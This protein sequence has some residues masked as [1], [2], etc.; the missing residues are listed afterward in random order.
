MNLSQET[1]KPWEVHA[2]ADIAARKA[3]QLVWT[4]EAQ[5]TL[6]KQTDNEGRDPQL[7]SKLPCPTLYALQ[8]AN[9]SG[10]DA[11]APTI[12]KGMFRPTDSVIF[13]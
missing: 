9:A 4:T 1:S 3:A 2:R 7:R 6:R 10:R 12:T 11:N 5:L 13:E 8:L